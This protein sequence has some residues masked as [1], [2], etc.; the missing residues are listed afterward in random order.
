MKD[1][2]NTQEE[3]N[4]ELRDKKVRYQRTHT[5]TIITWSN[6]QYQYLVVLVRIEG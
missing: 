3:T 1:Q 4:Q 2:L 6:S 5:N